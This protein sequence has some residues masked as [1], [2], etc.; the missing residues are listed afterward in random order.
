MSTRGENCKARHRVGF[1][2]L[3][4]GHRRHSQNAVVAVGSIVKPELSSHRICSLPVG[5]REPSPSRR[6]FASLAIPCRQI[7]QRSRWYLLL[8]GFFSKSLD[9]TRSLGLA[10]TTI[11][12]NRDRYVVCCCRQR[13]SPSC[14]SSLAMANCTAV[15]D[16]PS[17]ETESTC[18]KKDEGKAGIWKNCNQICYYFQT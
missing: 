13:A 8:S 18:C 2:P 4:F 16:T 5:D 9:F 3:H 7:C 17:P 12:A 10:T 1:V 15:D 14:S 6:W 11:T